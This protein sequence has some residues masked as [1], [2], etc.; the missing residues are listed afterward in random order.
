MESG[1]QHFSYLIGFFPV[2]CLPGLSAFTDSLFVSKGSRENKKAAGFATGG[3][4]RL[5]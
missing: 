1:D 2:L 5:I 4:R 3:Q